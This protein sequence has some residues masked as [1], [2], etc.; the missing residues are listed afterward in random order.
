MSSDFDAAAI[1]VESSGRSSRRLDRRLLV[2]LDS[3]GTGAGVGVA[4]DVATG[5][6]S[7][8]TSAGGIGM[9]KGAA[10]VG[11]SVPLLEGR[12]EETA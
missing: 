3:A 9:A 10:G 4:D 12:R 11:A 6:G 1:S 5:I 7:R 2:W 8:S